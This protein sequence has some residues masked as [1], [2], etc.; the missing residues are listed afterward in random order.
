MTLKEL[1][2]SLGLSL[3]DRLTPV[4]WPRTTRK[5]AGDIEIGG[6]SLAGI[7]GRYGTPAYV[8]DELDLRERC[9]EYMRAFAGEE[10]AYAGKALLTRAVARWVGEEGL[11]LDVCSAGE[12]AVA[13]AI[14][15]PAERVILHGNA[16]TPADLA[17][18][19]DYRVGR[20]VIDSLGEVARIAAEAER[21][22]RVLLRIVPGVDAHTH[23]ALTTGTEHQK[24]GLSLATGDAA[25]AARRVL[26]QRALRLCGVHA[27][28]GSQVSR[29]GAYEQE[30]RQLVAF[31]AG[32][33]AEHRITVP[34]LNIGG[35]HA[36]AYV[37]GD[38]TF[39][40]DDFATRIRRVLR[41]ECQ[42]NRLPV[43]RLTVEPGRAIAARAGV[44]IYHVVSVKRAGGRRLV[45]VDGGMSDNPRPSLYGAH[46]SVV[47][48]G[49]KADTAQERMTVVGRHCEAGDILAEDAP[50]PA[51]VR[52]GDLLAVPA[53]GAY[54]FPLAS[55]YN[56][57]GRPPLIAVRGGRARVLVRRE[58]IN[59]ILARDIRET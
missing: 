15:F 16:K 28:I 56:L 46:Y 32:L 17:Y 18:A 40:L 13:R 39:A 29:F 8:L 19:R 55:N 30:L 34:E 57:V 20:I 12:M 5:V 53:S 48:L 11:S 58:T 42:A 47:L 10:V 38:D 3:P 21:P 59:D 14:G 22:Q 27:H 4:V 9:R 44:A 52:P 54:H 41:F 43:P 31:L 33:Y 49:R 23:T 37:D 24:F 45:A 7:A 35:G 50:L 6:V 36:V 25:E 26:G 51:D 2:P 1:L